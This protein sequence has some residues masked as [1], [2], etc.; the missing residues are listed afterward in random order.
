MWNMALIPALSAL[1]PI[2]EIKFALAIVSTVKGMSVEVK[3]DFL[4]HALMI[5]V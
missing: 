1:P 3:G 5:L 4:P 2:F